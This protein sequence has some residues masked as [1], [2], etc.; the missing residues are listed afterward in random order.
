MTVYIVILLIIAILG[1][2]EYNKRL[3]DTCYYDDGYVY[4]KK[5]NLYFFLIVCVFL[6]VGGFRYQVGTDFG[7][8]YK[9]HM[10]TWIELLYRFRSL[11]EPLIYFITTICRLIWNEGIFVVFVLNAIT[12]SL[13]MKGIREWEL[14]SWTMPILLYVMYC[15]W[16]GSFNGVRQALA[17]AIIFAFSK[18]A[19]ERWI[20]KYLLVCFIAFLMH[21]TAIFMFPV[22]IVANRKFGF[23]QIILFAGIALMMPYIGDFALQAAGNSL[24]TEYAVTSVN[25]IRVIVSFVPVLLILLSTQEFRNENGFLINMAVINAMITVS[26]R[27]SALMFRF[28]DYTNMYLMLFIPKISNIFSENSRKLFNV[29]TVIL[30]FLYFTTEIRSGNGHLN[31]FQWAFGH[32]GQ[33]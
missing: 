31:D 23:K 25:I 32:F 3:A 18:R 19:E 26:T 20:L 28:A 1:N 15:G 9:G 22:L 24:N 13:V 14:E 11:D 33:F 12:V 6:F 5:N 4:Q 27:N 29:V 8:Y 2:L 10:A 30:Y 17:G 7:A 21:R 16:T